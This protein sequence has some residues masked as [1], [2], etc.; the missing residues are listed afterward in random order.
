MSKTWNDEDTKFLIDNY[1][2]YKNEE[3]GEMM[4]KSFRA[5]ASKARKLKLYK[6]DEVRRERELN[7]YT[8]NY[9][10][11][12]EVQFL[13]NNYSKYKNDELSEMMNRT[14]TSIEYKASNLKLY[15]DE[16]HHNRML[17][18][19]P[20]KSWSDDEIKYMVENYSDTRNDD[21]CK[22]LGRSL[23][24]ITCKARRLN[25]VKSQEHMVRQHIKSKD[26]VRKNYSDD[27]VKQIASKFKTRTEFRLNNHVA[28]RTAINRNM[29][30][31]VCSH[32]IPVSYSIPQIVLKNL[33]SKL[34]TDNYLY[35]TRQIIKPYELDIYLP[36]FNLAFE[37]N[38]KG[39]H[40]NNENDSKKNKLAKKIG[41]TIITII[42][43]SRRYEEDIKNQMIKFIPK[44]YKLTNIKLTKKQILDC[45]LPNP[46]DEVLDVEKINE[47]TQKY[48]D[49][50]EFRKCETSLYEKLLKIK[51]VEQFTSHMNRRYKLRNIDEVIEKIN[52]YEYLGD[53]IKY[54]FST[55]NYVRKNKLNHLLDK[56]IRKR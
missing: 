55:Y 15:K 3:L 33:I 54:E 25:L 1:S 29:L 47:I 21:L 20:I 14:S 31:E 51:M 2:N 10:T 13:I 30:D 6:D 43:N 17:K 49:F 8:I 36:D 7:G 18:E 34:I 38:G 52:K 53:L 19:N 35:N 5:I 44:I 50:T 56:L 26:S 46:Y 28:Y 23:R 42:E 27:D 39:W 24:S 32:M 12:D 48:T 37:Y 16:E 22:N 40:L 41:I 11:E 4:G 45:E 9:W